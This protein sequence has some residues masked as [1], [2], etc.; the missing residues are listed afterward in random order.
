MGTDRMRYKQLAESFIRDINDG[1]L[2]RGSK[3][4]SLR[5]LANQHAVSVSTAVSCYQE[6]ESL[7]WIISRPKAGFYVAAKPLQHC[8]RP[9]LLQFVSQVTEPT[10]NIVQP[11]PLNGPLG[12]SSTTMDSKAKTAIERSFRCAFKRLDDRLSH[13][14][15]YQG[16]PL[17][18]QALSQ[19]FSHHGFAFKS[20]ELVITGGC[21]SGVKTALEICTSAGDAVAISSPCFNGLITLL[22][23]MG[24]KIVE[25]PSTESGIDLDQLECHLEQGHI[26]AGLFCTTHMNPQGIT[27]SIEQKKRLVALATKFRTPI[28]EDDVY[29]ELSHQET[30][31]LPAKYFD[32]HGYILWCGSISKTLSP[33]YR[34]GWC[35]PGRISQNSSICSLRAVMESP[36]RFN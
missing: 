33:S 24:R 2:T 31:P 26:K 17:L 12:V 19:H 14:P 35:L 11:N 10:T 29:I 9:D 28:I 6:L 34:L 32:R 21:M 15:D 18:R 30:F 20:N 5:M 25:I 7:G 36:V 3:M 8:N 13:Y 1:K 16:E 27:M 4:P 23:T 22:A